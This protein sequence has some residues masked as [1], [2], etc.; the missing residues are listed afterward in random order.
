[1]NN[2][3]PY[4]A[5]PGYGVEYLEAIDAQ[6]RLEKVRE[7]T[8]NQLREV[9]ALPGVQK[10]IQQAAERRLRKILRSEISNLRFKSFSAP[11]GEICCYTT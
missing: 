8:A 10:T 1:M 2:P 5:P 9:I 7:F 6:S 3:F 11:V 4:K